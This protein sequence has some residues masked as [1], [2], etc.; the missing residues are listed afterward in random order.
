MVEN[1][2]LQRIVSIAKRLG[3]VL[4]GSLAF[5]V[6]SRL[7]IQFARDQFSS[8]TVVFHQFD[9]FFLVLRHIGG[10]I[11]LIS[12]THWCAFAGIVTILAIIMTTILCVTRKTI[13]KPAIFVCL[14]FAL[15]L[16]AQFISFHSQSSARLPWILLCCSALAAGLAA[17]QIKVSKIETS[18]MSGIKVWLCLLFIL[19]AGFLFRVYHLDTLPPGHAQHTAQ[20]GMLGAKQALEQKATWMSWEGIRFFLH[21]VKGRITVELNQEGLNIFVDWL[22]ASWFGPSLVVQRTATAMVG[23]LS[24]VALYW[25]AGINFGRKTACL[26]M[27]FA[28]ISPW[29]IMHSRYSSIEHILPLLL[30]ILSMGLLEKYLQTRSLKTAIIL[31]LVLVA[32][33]HVYVIAQFIVPIVVIVWLISIFQFE[34]FRRSSSITLVMILFLLSIGIAPKTGLYGCKG[35]ISLLNSSVKTHPSYVVQGPIII[36]KNTVTVFRGL[37]LNGKGSFWFDKA[38]GHLI[39]PVSIALVFGLAYALVNLKKRA[40]HSLVIWFFIGLIPALP[41]SDPAP[42]RLLCALPA[43]YILA[44]LGVDRLI[45]QPGLFNI[46]QNRWLKAG[47]LGALMFF[48][49]S[50]AWVAFENHSFSIEDLQ[51]GK[52]RRLAEIVCS[53]LPDHTVYLFFDSYTRIQKIWM[54]CGWLGPE[55]PSPNAVKFLNPENDLD[56]LIKTRAIQLVSEEKRGVV[57]I[58][59]AHQ[60]GLTTFQDVMKLFPEGDHQ[61]YRFD[62]RF[63]DH[64]KGNWEFQ[65]WSVRKHQFIKALEEQSFSDIQDDASIGQD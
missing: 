28:A 13:Y 47:L 36:V 2:K 53:F 39:W 12:D 29:H 40:F 9:S 22:L 61:I 14:S 62:P 24:L 19:I 20:W 37:F 51:N 45:I 46:V 49:V 52:E 54:I 65:S 59:P 41:S 17:Y 10:W 16:W 7:T 31:L 60:N 25:T 63:I 48:M 34:N 30:V 18:S 56:T 5:I 43:I 26:T 8:R 35:Q 57:F 4:I 1:D 6:V 33:F 64:D 11:F 27:F 55:E 21:E 42:R 15:G 23:L 32:D 58:L 38:N 50:G 3:A 44:A